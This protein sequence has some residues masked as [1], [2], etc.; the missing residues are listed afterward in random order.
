MMML[1]I[2]ALSHSM[3]HTDVFGLFFTLDFQNT[4]HDLRGHLLEYLVIFYLLVNYFNSQKRLE[5]LSLIVI[6]SA[7]AFSVGAIISY[8]FIDGHPFSTRFGLTFKEMNTDYI[9]FITTFGAILA[10]YHF[11][12]NK[13]SAYKILFIV[14]FL[15]MT[16]AT[17]FTQSRGSLIGLFVSLA[18]LCLDSRKNIIFIIIPLLFILLV[19]GIKDRASPENFFNDIRNKMNR[20]TLEVIKEYPITGVGFGMQIYGNKDL[21]PLEKYNSKLPPEYQQQFQ[22]ARASCPRDRC[23][24]RPRADLPQPVH[25]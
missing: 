23:I 7:M 13:T 5:T 25:E 11:Y 10:L 9:G 18:I 24:L 2:P 3:E 14:C 22:A 16:V 19:P 1:S 21:V 17:L 20:L 15:V 12:K 6:A 8:Y 4:L